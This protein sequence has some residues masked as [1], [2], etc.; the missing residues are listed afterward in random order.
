MF[1]KNGQQSVKLRIGFIKFKYHFKQ[2]NVSFKIDADFEFLLKEVQSNDRNNNTSCT[3]KY[4]K[5]VS[6]SFSYEVVVWW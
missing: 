3:E 5:H 1:E 6:Y 2:L 4:Q